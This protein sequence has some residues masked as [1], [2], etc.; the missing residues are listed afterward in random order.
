LNSN[1]AACAAENE[2]GLASNSMLAQLVAG[3]IPFHELTP[4]QRI[5]R[6]IADNRYIEEGVARKRLSRW[7]SAES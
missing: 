3:T 5:H 4:A 2:T 7:I 6:R 1:S